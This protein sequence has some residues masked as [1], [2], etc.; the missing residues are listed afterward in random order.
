MY[1]PWQTT[2]NFLL[3]IT[4]QASPLYKAAKAESALG[5]DSMIA[6]RQKKDAF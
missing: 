4:I 3:I 1:E 2:R 5:I 6:C